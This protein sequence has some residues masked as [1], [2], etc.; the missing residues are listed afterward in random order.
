MV[1]IP[2]RIGLFCASEIAGR[3][4]AAMP[5]VAAAPFSNLRRE[6]PAKLWV[7]FVL[8]LSPD[9]DVIFIIDKTTIV[10]FFITHYDD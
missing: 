6:A 9:V 1:G 5:A 10:F 2:M 3:P 7:Y 4:S 8:M